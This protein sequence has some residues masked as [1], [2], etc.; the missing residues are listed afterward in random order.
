M[1]RDSFPVSNIIRQQ[2]TA[3]SPNTENLELD[4]AVLVAANI[5]EFLLRHG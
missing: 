2:L 1:A 4:P 5:T 3:Q